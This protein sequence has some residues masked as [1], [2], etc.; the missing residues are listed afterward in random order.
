MYLPTGNTFFT[1]PTMNAYKIN[2]KAVQ[3]K[4]LLKSLKR[5]ELSFNSEVYKGNVYIEIASLNCDHDKLLGGAEKDIAHFNFT[6]K[7]EQDVY[8]TYY[9]LFITAAARGAS[10]ATDKQIGMLITLLRQNKINPSEVFDI[11]NT[12]RVFTK[13]EASNLIDSLV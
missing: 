13:S 1:P 2:T 4:N 10:G 11:T 12:S 3:S 9:G 5:N 7:T 8:S 6:R